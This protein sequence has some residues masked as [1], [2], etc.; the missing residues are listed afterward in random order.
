MNALGY[1]LDDKNNR[2]EGLT[3]LDQSCHF[4]SMFVDNTSLF[5]KENLKNLNKIINALE[6]YYQ[7]SR[8]K[9]NWHKIV[10]I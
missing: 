8:T 9:I 10:A 4:N 5:L 1:M 7:V 2:I 6:D 3:F